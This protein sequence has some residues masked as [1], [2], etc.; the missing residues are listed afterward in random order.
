MYSARTGPIALGAVL[1]RQRPLLYHRQHHTIGENPLHPDA[2]APMRRESRVIGW[3][4]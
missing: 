1:E 3:A 2:G 4:C